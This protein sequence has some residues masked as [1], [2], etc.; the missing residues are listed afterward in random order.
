MSCRCPASTEFLSNPGG[1]A[2]GG[3]QPGGACGAGTE[4]TWSVRRSVLFRTLEWIASLG[5]RSVL[6][7]W[8]LF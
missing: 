1:P 4:G 8:A 6:D 3:S 7:F 5:A 2:V